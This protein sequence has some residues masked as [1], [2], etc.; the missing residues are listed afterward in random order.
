M[1]TPT[2]RYFVTASIWIDL[3]DHIAAG[4]RRP[5]IGLRIMGLPDPATLNGTLTCR[6][7]EDADMLVVRTSSL[8]PEVHAVILS[9]IAMMLDAMLSE[10]EATT[11][12]MVRQAPAPVKRGW[13]T[14]LL[15]K[16][17]P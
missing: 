15:R 11:E 17:V 6:P 2:L 5:D 9:D 12:P 13:L 4:L 16:V 1:T 7:G 3:A 8:D 10:P 14:S